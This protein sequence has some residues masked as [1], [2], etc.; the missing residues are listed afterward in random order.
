MKMLTRFVVFVLLHFAL[1]GQAQDQML[2]NG[3]SL[4]FSFGFPPSNYGFDGDL[5]LPED[6]QVK[7]TF[8]LEIG[9]QWYF[10]TG[11]RFGLGLDV[12][13]ID[14]TYSREKAYSPTL[15]YANRITAEGSFLEFGPVGTFAVNDIV[16]LEG[17]YNLRPTYMAT[18]YYEDSDDYVLVE[19]FGFLHGI[20]LGLR[21]KFLYFGYE[22]TFGSLQGKL[23]G[24]G[25]YDDVDQLYGD[26][27]MD[28]KNSKLIIG[29]KF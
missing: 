24:G 29:F 3:F 18:Y 7:N 22:Y 25:E 12:N 17:Y 8:G 19:D 27:T 26:Q 11:E 16:A 15:G 6:L 5:P 21:V 23:I 9:N 1:L 28:A 20:G 10:Y 4:K 2:E 14:L 13:W